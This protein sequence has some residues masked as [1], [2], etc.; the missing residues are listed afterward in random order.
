MPDKMVLLSHDIAYRPGSKRDEQKELET[1]LKLSKE[2]GYIFETLDYYLYTKKWREEK[3]N[4]VMTKSMAIGS[5]GEI[6]D[7]IFSDKKEF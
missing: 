4:E 7:V 3:L 2:A 5:S 1:F 6:S